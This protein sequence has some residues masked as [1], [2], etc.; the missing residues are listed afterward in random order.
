MEALGSKMN[1]FQKILPKKELIKNDFPLTSIVFHR[2]NSLSLPKLN[3]YSY[4]TNKNFKAIF[5]TLNTHI[6][7]K[8]LILSYKRSILKFIIIGLILFPN[9]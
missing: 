9:S 5:L 6:N 3:I 2:T 1:L 7:F 4:K 8:L